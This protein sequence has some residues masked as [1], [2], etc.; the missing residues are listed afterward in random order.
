MKMK[1]IPVGNKVFVEVRMGE[2]SISFE[3]TVVMLIE[4]GLLVEEYK[5]EKGNPVSFSVSAKNNIQVNGYITEDKKPPTM[6]NN[7]TVK[8]VMYK[9]VGHHLII[10]DSEGVQKNRRGSYRLPLSC[11]AFV[12]VALDTEKIKVV[13]RD[14]SATGFSFVT[15]AQIDPSK[16]VMM[17]VDGDDIKVRLKGS[18]VWTKPTDSRTIYGCKL[19]QF[20]AALDKMIAE[21][22]RER[23]A[24][25]TG[26]AP[27]PN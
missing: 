7:I 2:K 23:I 14:M 1:E 5:D 6:W 15:N 27:K 9:G 20:S 24:G 3:S 21:K 22:Q 19:A 13:A 8:R 26:N 10:S 12:T 18:I 25:K 17:T 11:E 16:P 4:E